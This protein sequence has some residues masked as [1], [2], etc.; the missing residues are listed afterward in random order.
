GV[1]P[2]NVAHLVQRSGVSE[3]HLRAVEQ[4]PSASLVLSGYDSGM[5]D[6]TSSTIVAAV[7]DALREVAA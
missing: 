7:V 5:R 1:R 2:T 3:V 4:A 6:V